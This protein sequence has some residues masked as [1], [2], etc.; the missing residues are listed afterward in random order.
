ML[1]LETLLRARLAEVPALLGVYGARERA[2]MT[3]RR[4]D[5]PVAFVAFDGYSVLETSRG[6]GAARVQARWLVTVTV[7]AVGSP[8]DGTALRADA[9]PIVEAVLGKL[10]GWPPGAPYGP[11][12]LASSQDARPEYRADAIRLPLAFTTT[13]VANGDERLP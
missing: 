3:W 6:G 2:A 13:F 5:F 4:Q 8:A 12:H 10:L 11:L 1:G 9:A 7:R